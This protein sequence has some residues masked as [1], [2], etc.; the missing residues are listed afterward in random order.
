MS[1]VL[2]PLYRLLRHS[3]SWRWG[4]IEHQ[5]FE[6]ISK[7]LLTSAQLL[8]H[9]DPELELILA[10]DASAHGIG[11]VLSHRMPDSSEKPIGFVS[12]T[13][14][15]TEIKY[16]Q[17]EKEGLS[18]VFGVK[19]FHSNLYGHHFTLI[20]DHK[21]L[22]TLFSRAVPPQ[23]SGRIQRWALT[24][25]AYE[26]TLFWCLTKQ[27]ENADAMSRL[28]LPKKP[29]ET[30]LPAELVL[31]ME[32]LEESPVAATQ[33]RMWTRRDPLLSRVSRYLH[34]GWPDQCDD[35]L[36]PYCCHKMELS[37]HDDCLLWG[38][39]VI[40]PPP[41][42]EVVLGE[43]H[44]G[45]PGISRMKTLARMFVWWPSMDGDIVK[46]VQ[47]CHICQQYRPAPPPAPLQP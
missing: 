30:P 46:M 35:Q 33:I 42:R 36:K 9:Y 8:V 6:H 22:H 43:L 26:Y 3:T 44:A 28:P 23:A 27:H 17:I 18:C 13:L 38:S 15:K 21:P 41:A 5:A 7:Q 16:L 10:C 25:A 31:L 12:R 14:S 47:S 29:L 40:I 45:H 4:C 2:A 37:L 24:L 1:T 34:E 32:H 20:I 19:K 39:R 11:A